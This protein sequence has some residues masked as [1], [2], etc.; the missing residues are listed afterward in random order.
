[1]V[2]SYMKS[3]P[4]QF[5]PQTERYWTPQRILQTF[6]DKRLTITPLNAPI[7]LFRLGLLN[8]DSSM[9]HQ[10]LRKFLQ[11]N[12]LMSLLK[13]HLQ[14]LANRF[15]P[16]VMIDAGCGKSYLTFLLAWYFE[17][18]LKH[19]AEIHGIDQ[20]PAIISGCIKTAEEL[21]FLSLSFHTE[22]L[23][24]FQWPPPK[25]INETARRP[26]AVFGLHACDTASDEACAL[27]LSLKSDLIAIAPCCQAELAHWWKE[28][29]DACRDNPLRPIF[30]TAHIRRE[31]A[32]HFTDMLRM[33]FLRGHGYQTTATEFIPSEHTPKN[34]LITAVRVG[35][36]LKSAQEE[37]RS[38]KQALGSP[39]LAL[40]REASEKICSEIGQSE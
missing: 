11:I 23:S 12:H 14:E 29:T 40:E 27:A 17:E 9:N 1:M 24:S 10:S 31:M 5:I 22:S 4:D 36:Y 28:N 25:S 2:N 15:S 38:L 21:G 19:P 39:T 6:G 18:I 7:L 34:R 26:H 32:A 30:Q 33:L 37:F 8:K 3:I 13:P 35:S 20:R 16:V